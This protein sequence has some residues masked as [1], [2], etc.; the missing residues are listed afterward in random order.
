MADNKAKAPKFYKIDVLCLLIALEPGMSQR[1]YLRRLYALYNPTASAEEVV[2][3]G[4]TC[5][6]YFRG[7]PSWSR[8]RSYM[9]TLFV[10]AG[11]QG[12]SIAAS[13]RAFK[14]RQASK[15]QLTPA[16]MR[17]AVRLAVA[18]WNQ[19]TEALVR[20]IDEAADSDASTYTNPPVMM[21]AAEA[22]CE[23]IMVGESA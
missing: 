13:G 12:R 16:G 18:T 15:M 2:R 1:H 10:N 21:L 5:C 14:F 4:N 8:R 17:R 11:L 9:G 7:T 6:Q 19:D 23:L 20:A 22:E 3:H